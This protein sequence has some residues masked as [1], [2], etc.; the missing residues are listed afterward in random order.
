[1]HTYI[2]TYIDSYIHTYIHTYLNI[3]HTYCFPCIAVYTGDGSFVAKNSSVIVSRV[4]A[5]GSGMG[6]LARLKGEKVPF[7]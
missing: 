2:H 6:L 4:P 5:M 7:R 1:M 3:M